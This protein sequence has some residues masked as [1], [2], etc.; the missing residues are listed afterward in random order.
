MGVYLDVKKSLQRDLIEFSTMYLT[1]YQGNALPSL[2]SAEEGQT[3]Y[4]IGQ[5][6]MYVVQ[7][8]Q[9]ELGKQWVPIPPDYFFLDFDGHSQTQELP[10]HHLVGTKAIGLIVDEHF[11]ETSFLA[12]VTMFNDSNFVAHDKIVDALFMRYLPT[13]KVK[14]YTTSNGQH[15]G[16]LIITN[17]T[18]IM[19]MAKADQRPIQFI[20]VAANTDR[21]VSLYQQ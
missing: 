9:T 1:N 11:V 7:A 18:E 4:H 19:P 8:D 14:L 13:K 15:N 2:D 21:T 20:S 17:G 10:T 3:A 5:D 16:D 6:Q 12:V